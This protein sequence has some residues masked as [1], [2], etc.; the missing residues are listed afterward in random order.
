M[1]LRGAVRLPWA[2]GSFFFWLLFGRVT[3][4]LQLSSEEVQD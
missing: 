3:T 4:E 1:L 2:L